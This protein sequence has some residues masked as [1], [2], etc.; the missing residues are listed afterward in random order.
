[1]S[2]SATQSEALE[3]AIA[4]AQSWNVLVVCAAG[5]HPGSNT[6]Y[7]ARYSLDYNNVIAVS[8]T[9]HNDVFAYRYSLA[10]LHINVS[11]PGG[12][13]PGGTCPD[14]N[15]I[16]STL[17][18]YLYTLQA[19]CPNL[20]ESYD[21]LFGTSMAA[22]IVTGIAALIL[23]VNP[24]LTAS[25]VRDILQ[26]TADDKG[27][28]GFDWYYGYGRVNAYKSLINVLQ[29]IANQN[30]T[31]DQ[32]ATGINNGRRFT[33]DQNGNYHFVFTSGN[34]I[35]YKKSTD[36]GNSW[37][38][39]VHLSTDGGQN[40]YPSIAAHGNFV[41]VTWQQYNGI[42]NNQHKYTIQ[43]RWKQI[44]E[45]DWYSMSVSSPFYF[46]S[47]TDPTPVIIAANNVDNNYT[48]AQGAPEIM[49]GFRKTTGY[50]T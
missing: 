10:G 24:E 13:G 14:D 29:A 40:R 17:P 20:D 21:Y 34:N 7:P 28:P 25:Q 36:N 3:T 6:Q 19:I 44:N 35:F 18:N 32:T 23:S 43:G 16:Y 45:T 47:Q 33:N 27:E 9:D 50:I 5:N 22:P 49:V 31:L 41:F 1:M 42:E 8:A 11:A 38:S 46:T 15:D 39:T 4:N 2:L 48:S 30:K 26:L 37:S 12:Y